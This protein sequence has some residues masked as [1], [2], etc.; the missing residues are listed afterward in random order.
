MT[1]QDARRCAFEHLAV[2]HDD[3]F[4]RAGLARLLL[5][6]GTLPSNIV[7]LM[8]QRPQRKSSTVITASPVGSLVRRV[9]ACSAADMPSRTRL[10]SQ[11]CRECVIAGR[12]PSRG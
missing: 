12:T 2:F 6:V 5:H 8:S 11:S 10:V 3:R 7:D 9:I 4:L 1:C